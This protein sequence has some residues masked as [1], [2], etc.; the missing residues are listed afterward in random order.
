MPTP[1]QREIDTLY[2]L[3]K[4][5]GVPVIDLKEMRLTALGNMLPAYSRGSEAVLRLP[6]SSRIRRENAAARS[7]LN[8]ALRKLV[9]L[10]DFAGIVDQ[11][12]VAD[13]AVG[14]FRHVG[15][16]DGK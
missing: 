15:R 11:P 8:D 2:Q 12:I 3:L 6:R 7:Q 1:Q 13:P 9:Q 14:S 10:L 16:M 4:S 5:L